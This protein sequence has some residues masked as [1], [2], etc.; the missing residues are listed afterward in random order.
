[1]NLVGEGLLQVV[2]VVMKHHVYQLLFLCLH[3]LPADA[4]LKG[5]RNRKGV[6]VA[7]PVEDYVVLVEAAN[8]V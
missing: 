2:T 3:A 5:L 6:H 8:H 4:L 7:R 1:M